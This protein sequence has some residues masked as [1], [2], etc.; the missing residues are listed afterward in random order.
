MNAEV[1]VFQTPSEVSDLLAM[2]TARFDLKIFGV[3]NGGWASFIAE[4]GQ[5]RLIDGESGH[6]AGRFDRKQA[7][8][9]WLFCEGRAE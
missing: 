1:G 5:V 7:I 3:E 8:E 9:F 2:A 4:H 6:E